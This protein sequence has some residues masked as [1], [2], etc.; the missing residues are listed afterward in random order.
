MSL[1]RMMTATAT[2][3]RLPAM[4]ND[5]IGDP[6]AH[7]ASVKITPVMLAST[8]GQ[9][10]IRQAIGLEGTAIQV[11]ECYTESHLHTDGGVPVTQVPDIEAGDRLVVGSVT[12]EVL[13]AE[14]QPAT[15]G[16]GATLMLYITEDKRA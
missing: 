11:F 7:L 10:Q 6:V 1:S 5:K 4:V 8:T 12:Y 13:W 16:F 9:H 3:T 2:T 14:Q 15:S